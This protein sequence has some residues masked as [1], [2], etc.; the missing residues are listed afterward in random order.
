MAD[1]SDYG[2]SR[3]HV[4]PLAKQLCGLRLVLQARHK[5]HTYQQRG[6]GKYSVF[7]FPSVLNVLFRRSQTV[8][9]QGSWLVQIWVS[10][11]KTG[12]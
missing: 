5:R 7:T 8:T 1:P 12:S 4:C 2:N 6:G 9:L 10:S 3:D 11:L